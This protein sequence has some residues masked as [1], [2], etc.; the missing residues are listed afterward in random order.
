MPMTQDNH[1]VP[2]LYLKNFGN[3]DGFLF[4]YRTLV[5]NA[6]IPEW[7]RMHLSGVGYQK[8]LYTRALLDGDSDDIEQW[9]S[10]DFETP[11]GETL[12]KIAANQPLRKTDYALLTRFAAAQMVRTPAFYLKNVGRWREEGG[13]QNED[14]L[15]RV[16][17]K[18]EQAHAAGIPISAEPPHPEA[19]YYP[20]R[21][22]TEPSPNPGKAIIKLQTMVGRATW[23]FAMRHLLTR[24]V[25]K[26]T[27][28]KWSIIH[29]DDALPWFT[30]DDPVVALNFRNFR[31]YDFG[32]G[33]G[34]P[35]TNIILPL[36]PKHLLYTQIGDKRLPNGTVFPRHLA[37][38]LRKVIAEHA[39][40]YI[41]SPA[42]DASIP[43]L[44]PRHIDAQAV[45]NETELW[46]RWHAEQSSAER[47][48]L[49][50]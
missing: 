17:R 34:V 4:R 43:F 14:S 38:F 10:K 26:F 48:L 5:S 41:F 25:E 21:F 20:M 22:T 36:S 8:H 32:G 2:R 50:P 27:H 39:H 45:K 35:H 29:A 42:P 16:R 28:H 24:T 37:L 12:A 9:L 6:A 31:E 23:I 7:K 18:L 19:K 3:A 1:Y 47:E 11:A 44:R 49:Q 46:E 15:Q 13:R 33:W 40:R 30:T